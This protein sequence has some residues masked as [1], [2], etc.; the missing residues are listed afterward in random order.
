MPSRARRRVRALLPRVAAAG[1]ALACAAGAAVPGTARADT[2][3]G[4]LTPEAVDAYMAEYLDSTALPGATVAVTKDGSVV[5]TAG[6]GTD[7]AGEPLAADTPMGL[8]S[9]SKAFTGAAVMRLVEDGRVG[10]DEPVRTYLPEFT[11]ADPR[12]DRITVRHLLTQTSGLSDS[13]FREKS[14]PAPDSLKGAV[15][16]LSGVRL[17]ADPGTEE[18]YHNPNYHVAARMVEVVSGEPFA[19]FLDDAVFTPLGM[20]DTVTVDTAADVA[21]SGVADGHVAVLGVPVSLPEPE[22]FFNGAGGMAST[23]DDMAAW[24]AAQQNGGVGPGGG[25]IL[26]AEGIEQTHTPNGTEPGET[27]ALGW[28]VGRTGRGAPTIQ[29]GGIQFTYT[30]EQALL[31]ESGYGI[32]VMAGSGLGRGDA[33]AIMAGLI[34]LSEGAE[35]PAP[36]AAALMAVDVVLLALGALTA[37]L[38]VRGL[39]RAA[40]WARR[41]S[42]SPWW[43]AALRCLPYVSTVFAA[44]A[45]HRLSAPLAGGRDLPW[46]GA[47]Y[48][49]PTLM[50]F[51]LVAAI[52]G[53]AVLVARCVHLLRGR[54]AR[55]GAAAGGRAAGEPTGEPMGEP[56]G[57]TRR[58]PRSEPT[59]EPSGGPAGEATEAGSTAEREP[60]AAPPRLTP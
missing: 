32:A 21:A 43:G 38:G 30:A 10:L 23:A 17:V 34:A 24:L 45:V 16:R 26:S 57:E 58:E 15:A 14:E 8:A 42:G 6:Y 5:H 31:P 56:T 47:V 29:H 3:S 2:A 12:S 40:V 25:R 20:A 35:P 33:V 11:T 59:G 51:L 60:A 48:T 13:G 18:N 52:S 53:A 9:V 22:S 4:G 44:L 7:S 37:L 50:L 1:L 39:C 27:K 54:R 55:R 36:P 41:R 49:A 28:E 46:I 19:D